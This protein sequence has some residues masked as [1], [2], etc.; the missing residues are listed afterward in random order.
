M[1]EKTRKGSNEIYEECIA[2]RD[3]E[4]L[5]RLCLEDLFFLISRGCK[6]Q[7]LNNDWLYARCREVEAEPNGY[8]DLWSREHYKSTIITYGLTIQDILNNPDL[9]VGIFSHTRPI[10]KAFLSQIKREFELNTFLQGLFPE[11]LYPNPQKQSPK[12]S[13]DD[14]IIVKRRTNPKE[15][16]I[17][18]H[19]LVD[20]QPT[21]KHY[22]L[23]VYDDVVTKESVSTGDMI[24]KVTNSF[25]LSL[26]LGAQGGVKRYIGTRYH[27]LIGDTMIT[28]GDWSQKAIKDIKIGDTIVGWKKENNTRWLVKSKVKDCGSYKEQA[29]NKYI[30]ND[31]RSIVSTEDHKWWRGAN[32]SG[33]EYKPLGLHYHK[34]KSVRSVFIPTEEDKSYNSGWLSGFFS[35]DGGMRKN[36]NHPSAVITF[37]QTVQ[38]DNNINKLRECLSKKNFEWSE[39]KRKMDTTKHSQ[40]YNFAINGGWKERY[41]F[42]KEINPTKSNKLEDSLFSALQTDKIDLVDIKENGNANVYWIETETENYIANGFCSKNSND[43]YSTIMKRGTAIPRLYPATDDGT[44]KGK[45]VLLSQESFDEKVRDMGSYT[46]SCQLLQNPLADNAMGFNRDWIM[47]YSMLRD[48]SQWN[49]YI[50]VDPAGEKKKDN[51]YTVMVVIGL[52]PDGNYYLVDGLRDRMNL[53]ERTNALFRLHR[54]WLPKATGYEKY[55]MQSDIEHIKYI[56]DKVENYRFHIE[57]LGGSTPKNDRIRKLVPVFENRRF[58]I[59][60][61]MPFKTVDDKLVDFVRVFLEDEYDTFPVSSHDDMFDCIARIMDEKLNAVFPKVDGSVMNT[62]PIKMQEYDFLDTKNTRIYE[63]EYN[64]LAV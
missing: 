29:V 5:R 57:E 49:F 14:G 50:L 45:P 33:K 30:F 44:F 10:A 43:T 6:R 40:C 51:D 17:E 38:Y 36:T 7:D 18:A 56:Q 28:M 31:G 24:K 4:A 47:Q 20:G 63:Q 60:F 8:I 55:G 37:T 64:P 39:Y 3:P 22:S 46:A 27:C 59:P 54:K 32:G 42:L 58:F 25:E 35:A 62:L 26:N 48:Y 16:T 2:A 15:A 9:T 11:I 23:M 19:G 53:T 41:R 21:S 12:W 1:Q 61:S 52:A 13:L 34:M